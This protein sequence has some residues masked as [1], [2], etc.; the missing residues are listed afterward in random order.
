MKLKKWREQ[1]GITQGA[2]AASLGVSDVSV[3]RYENGRIPEPDV[4]SAI[5]AITN[6]SVCP[7]DFYGIA[8]VVDQVVPVDLASGAAQ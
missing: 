4:M 6:G 2:L 5:Y 8:P 3:S 1:E 7:N